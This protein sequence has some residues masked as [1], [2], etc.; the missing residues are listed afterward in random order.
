MR[1]REK[2]FAGTEVQVPV[3]A[4]P[5]HMESAAKAAGQ[6]DENPTHQDLDQDLVVGQL[7][8]RNCASRKMFRIDPC[9]HF[10]K[11]FLTCTW[12]NQL[13]VATTHCG[14]SLLARPQVRHSGAVCQKTVESGPWELS[15]CLKKRSGYLSFKLLDQSV[16]VP[17]LPGLEKAAILETEEAHACDLQSLA[18]GGLFRLRRPSHTH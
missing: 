5:V 13:C 17:I 2:F 9:V 12:M 7:E 18:R 11:A 8:V 6:V 14:H 16:H 15:C 4:D 1:F 10:S 3:N